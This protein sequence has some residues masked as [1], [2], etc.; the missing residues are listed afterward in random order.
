MLRHATSD[1]RQGWGI[2]SIVYGSCCVLLVACCSGC[3][4]RSLTIRTEPPGALVYVN[5]DLKGVSPVTYDFLWY[6][7]HRVILRKEGY[8]RVEDRRLLRA[9]IHLWIPFDLAMELL[10]FPVRDRRTWA[11]AL[12]PAAAPPTPVPPDLLTAPKSG[13]KPAATL[14]APPGPLAPRPVVPPPPTPPTEPAD[15]APAPEATP[16]PATGPS[17]GP[18]APTTREAQ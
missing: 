12:T 18:S 11:Y 8:E 7:W 5:D 10:P 16:A 14:L 1:Q 17:E 9:P 2:V 6:G 4:Y 3:I 13:G 15:Q